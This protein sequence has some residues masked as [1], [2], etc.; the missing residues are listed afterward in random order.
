[1][2]ALQIL[3]ELILVVA[4]PLADVVQD[5]LFDLVAASVDEESQMYQKDC[6]RFAVAEAAGYLALDRLV[7]AEVAKLVLVEALVVAP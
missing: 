5:E 1:M 4:L 6:F 2:V 3:G 7:V